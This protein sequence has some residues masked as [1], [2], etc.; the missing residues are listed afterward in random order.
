MNGYLGVTTVDNGGCLKEFE[1]HRFLRGILWMTDV[2]QDF[3]YLCDK[4][5]LEIAVN[6]EYSNP[7]T[8]IRI[9]LTSDFSILPVEEENSHSR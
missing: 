5:Q 9:L 6:L 2:P 3:F 8:N 4:R 7:G 1:N